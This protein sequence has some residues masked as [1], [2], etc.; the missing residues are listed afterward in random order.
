MELPF[1]RIT[2]KEGLEGNQVV[3]FLKDRRGF[4][5][6]GTNE[7]LN[8]YDGYEFKVYRNDPQDTTSLPYNH[9]SQ[10]YEDKEG[11]L[12][13]GTEGGGLI[14]LDPVTEIFTSYVYQEADPFSIPGDRVRCFAE[15]QQGNIWIGLDNRAGLCRFNKATGRFDRFRIPHD[16][17]S[18]S[19]MGNVLAIRDMK[20]DRTDSSKLWLATVGGLMSFNIKSEEL[21]LHPHPVKK[22]GV[23]PEYA[24]WCIDQQSDNELRVGFFDIGTDVFNTETQTWKG[25][26]VQPSRF[27]RVFDLVRKSTNEYWL[28]CR[29]KSVAILDIETDKIT[30]LETDLSDVTTP[31]PGFTH[32][33]YREGD[34]VWF[35][36]RYGISVY[37]PK[38][39]LF[40]V[41]KLPFLSDQGRIVCATEKYSKRYLGG[42]NSYGIY[43][44]DPT[45]GNHGVHRPTSRTPFDMTSFAETESK[46]YLVNFPF[47]IYEFDKRTKQFKSL[48][49]EGFSRQN[50][51]DIR[52][53]EL[54]LISDSVLLIGTDRGGII[55]H[56]LENQ[57]TK[58]FQQSLTGF[59]TT[60][61]ERMSDGTYW[62]SSDSGIV[63]YSDKN[64]TF[65][66]VFL[67]SLENKKNQR[68]S[69][70]KEHPEGVFWIGTESGLVKMANQSD[71]IV[72]SNGKPISGHAITDLELDDKGNLWIATDKGISVLDTE[73][74]SVTNF[75]SRSGLNYNGAIKKLKNGALWLSAQLGYILFHPDSLF[76]ASIKPEVVL[77]SF[78]LFDQEQELDKH[79]DFTRTLNL[80]YQDNF[81]SF[82][83]VSPTL[84]G[85]QNVLYSYWLEGFDQDWL[86]AGDRRYASY[87]NLSG[88]FYKFHVRAK[89]PGNSWGTTR[90]INIMIDPP[91]WETWWFITVS[92]LVFTGIIY[93]L[94]KYRLNQALREEKLRSEFSQKLAEVEMTALRAQMNPHFLFNSINSINSYIIKNSIEEATDYLSKFSRLIR[95]ILHHSNAKII[96]LSEEIETIKLYLEMEA[97]RFDGKFEYTFEISDTIEVD[98][99]EVPPMI[100]QPY[101]ENAIWHG[102]LH[103]TGDAHL[104]LVFNQ[105]GENLSVTIEDNGIGRKAAAELKSKSA[106]KK[107][108]MGMKI[109]QDRIEL[110]KKMYDV[111]PTVTI[112]DKTDKKG[113]AEG[114]VVHLQIPLNG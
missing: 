103:K 34:R 53:R 91:Y 108:S 87:T 2:E 10:L 41:R 111:A 84:S 71:E 6:I 21:G 73:T 33:V 76:S 20:I 100:I 11:L 5:W 92:I 27:I 26:N 9:I 57:Q 72:A 75:D 23:Y 60:D 14:V 85:A 94:Y 25:A 36:G 62:I 46:L 65:D 56:N 22:S 1:Q 43:E 70:F 97:L 58:H 29:E 93:R 83:F 7:G 16:G 24:T 82:S 50:L 17:N 68:I 79:I 47:A 28:A 95:L 110:L 106:V 44:I 88:G 39:N 42:F 81:F 54:E 48:V 38:Q 109:T 105:F 59:N 30:F 15:D 74:L 52:P 107:K 80:S 31:F 8:R 63:V 45:T 113:N 69:S 4:L 98:Y 89:T 19:Q 99:V 61:F 90:T 66:H 12:W 101:I 112:E 18:E 13:I 86:P 35:G 77:T 104:R 67:K 55:R 40:P 51:I 3:V 32:T 64:Q 37:D 114:T 102:L 49:L 78:K 96:L